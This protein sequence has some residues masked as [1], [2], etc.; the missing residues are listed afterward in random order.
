MKAMYST[1]RSDPGCS[2]ASTYGG[3]RQVNKRMGPTMQSRQHDEGE[4]PALRIRQRRSKMN[5]ETEH[6]SVL[7]FTQKGHTSVEVDVAREVPLTIIV[8]NRELVTLLCSPTNLTYLAVGFLFS[9]GFLEGK[10]EIRKVMVDAD[11]GVVRLETVDD[12]EFDRDVLFKRVI[13]S[14]CGRGA[15]FYSAA[16]AASQIV[17][18]EMKIPAGDIFA[19][20]AEFQHRSE[21]YLA[22]H[23]VHSAALSDGKSILVL[24][25]D[26]GRH[27]AIDKVF[28]RCLLE[29]IPT[30]DRVIVTSGRVSSEILHKVARRRIPVV[31]S[32]SAPT[33]LGVRIA[34]S[35]GITLVGL[36]R[37]KK[38]NVYTHS[39]RIAK[40][41]E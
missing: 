17:E 22:T 39:R 38:M 15:S 19:L 12:K 41:E 27:N 11:R 40:D 26:I 8:N 29:D 24:S 35:L 7:R 10:D 36:V 3:Q 1:E 4:L 14:G 20:V 32:I 16:D 23:G 21:V 30:N 37:G 34:D 18:S 9:E 31:I 6:L 28:G 2:V 13:S 33:S 25:N 5:Q